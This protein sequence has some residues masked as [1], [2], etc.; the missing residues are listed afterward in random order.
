[1][2]TTERPYAEVGQFAWLKVVGVHPK[3]GAFLDWG[4][5]KDLLLPYS[6]QPDRVREGQGVLVYVLLDPKSMRVIATAKLGKYLSHEPAPFNLGDSVE[7]LVAGRTDRG[8]E[9]IVENAHRGML[10]LNELPDPPAPG[11]KMRAFVKDVRPDGKID[12]TVHAMGYGKVKPLGDQILDAL[13]ANGGGLPLDDK[14]DPE[15]IREAFGVSKKAFKQALGA[16]YR[17]RQIRFDG[18]GTELT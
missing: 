14:S 13:R 10:F 8:I 7:I 15:V 5:S 12:L 9:A 3:I 18:G 16:L 4:L 1:M 6:E 2:A 11:T 17:K